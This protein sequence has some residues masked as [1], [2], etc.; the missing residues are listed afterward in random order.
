MEPR[1]LFDLLDHTGD[2]TFAVGP[3]GVICY[4]SRKAEQLLGFSQPQAL[5]KNCEDILRG[6]DGAGCEVCTRDCHVLEAARK[7]RDVPNYDLH[8]MT[9]SGTRKWLNISIIVAQV[10]QGPSPLVI[11]LMRD[12]SN[13]KRNEELTREIMVRVGELTGRQADEML[14]RTRS[15]RPSVELTVREL[16]ILRSL[17]LGRSTSEMA[18]E[19]HISTATV[20][21]HIQH[22]LAKLQCHTRLEAVLR[23]ARQGLI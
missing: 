19:L 22:I 14:S 2:A 18:A 11:H 1:E 9:G 21:N 8:A 12:I 5:S 10:R 3:R 16:S 23:A 17:S 6:E 20:R 15:E 4:W 7:E 13:R